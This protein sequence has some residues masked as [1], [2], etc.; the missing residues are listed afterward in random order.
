MLASVD[1]TRDGEL[2]NELKA[3]AAR[4][5]RNPR[6]RPSL[7]EVDRATFL[8][9]ESTP[10]P[11]T[12]AQVAAHGLEPT[13]MALCAWERRVNGAPIVD[14]A[15]DLGLSI[16]A[17]KALIREVHAAIRD[18]LKD[19][20]ELNRQLDLDRVD[21]LL[22]TFY[23]QARAG[24]IESATITI[25]ALQHRAKLVGLEPLPDPG[26]NQQPQNVLVWIQNQL[27]AINRIVDALPPELP[28]GAPA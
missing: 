27:P 16:E 4:K 18:D 1:D 9:P 15:H 6:S 12:E 17:S 22:Q 24:N 20:L 5:R 2:V 25:R 11:R 7:K 13:E 26:R 8:D 21:G 28:P 10:A 23:P 19:A 14:V 3:L